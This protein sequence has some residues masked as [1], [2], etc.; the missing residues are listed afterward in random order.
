[1]KSQDPHA[2]GT[3]FNRFE[4]ELERQRFARTP[5][6]RVPSPVPSRLSPLGLN[7]HINL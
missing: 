3:Q 6:V 4:L 1:V 7:D 5:T 2:S